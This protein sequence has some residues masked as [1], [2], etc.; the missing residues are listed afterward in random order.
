MSGRK[1]WAEVPLFDADWTPDDGAQLD[2][3]TGEVAA[4]TGPT[5]LIPDSW[6]AQGAPT[7]TRPAVALYSRDDPAWRTLDDDA[8]GSPYAWGY[9][10]AAADRRAGWPPMTDA[11]HADLWHA[12]YPE[13]GTP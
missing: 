2:I 6:T 8:D 5:R 4:P 13:W 3:F 7:G 9:E 10:C 1:G 11:E 12:D